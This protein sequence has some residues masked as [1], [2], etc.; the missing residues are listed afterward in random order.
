M[1]AISF[2][3]GIKSSHLRSSQLRDLIYRGRVLRHAKI[4]GDDGAAGS[5]HVGGDTQDEPMSDLTQTLTTQ[6]SQ[7]DRGDPKTASVMAVYEDDAG[8]EQ[9]WKRSITSQGASEYRINNRVVTA[10]QYNEA[11]EAENILIKARNFLVFQG[12]VEAI[13]SQSPKDLTRLIEQISGSLE[14]KAEYDRRKE[15]AEQ[16]TEHQNNNLN[17][18]RGINSEV[19]QYQ[20]QKREAEHY[21]AKVD[22]RNRAIVTHVLWKLFHFQRVMEESGE[23]IQRHQENLKE[24]Q[25]GLEK[26]EARLEEARKDQAKA[27]REASKLERTVKAKRREIEDQEHGLIPVDEKMAITERNVKSYTAKMAE[28]SKEAETQRAIVHKLTKDLDLVGK[29]QAKWEGHWQKAAAHEGRE[30]SEADLREYKSLKEQVNMRASAHQTKVDALAREQK[31]DEDTVNS[32]RSR[33]DSAQWQVQRFEEE[34]KELTGRRDRI[35][36]QLKQTG[37]EINAKKKDLNALS[38]ERLRSTQKQTELDEKLQD[39]L[40]ALLD[41]DDG[42]RQTEREV[43]M[44]ETIATLK[45]IYPGVRG[46]VGELCKPRQ[47]K[48]GDAVS[49]VLGRHFDS[50]VVDTEKTAKDCIQY[51]RDQRAGQATFI[52]L[53]T[54]Q[55]KTPNPKLKGMHSG[56][57]MA[58]DTIEY[59]NAY[60]RAM[61]YACGNAVVCD[62]LAI[63]KY[64][65]YDKGVE[66]KAVTLDGIIIHR[67]G[68]ITGGRGP[69]QQNSRR[70]DEAAVEDLRVMRD[71]FMA[72][73]AAL[74]KDGK[75]R[76][77]EESLLGELTGLEQSVSYRKEE[78]KALERNIESKA[79]E[80]SF[81]Q[82][83]LAELQRKHEEKDQALQALRREL[84]EHRQAVREV[85]DEVLGDFCRRLG[86]HDIREYEAQQGS[87][88]QEGAQKRL[89]FTMQRS[90]LESQLSF[91]SQ[92][93]QS[94]QDRLDRLRDKANHDEKLLRELQAEKDTID[95]TLDAMK[96]ELDQ[97]QQQLEQQN[98]QVTTKA[99]KVAEKRR[100]VQKRS[101]DVEGVRKSVAGLEADIQRNAAGR[102]VLLRRCK[103]E[104][105]RIPLADDSASLEAIPV[106]E[107]LRDD[108]DAMDID[109]D[110]NTTTL[111]D[112]DV[113]DYGVQPDFDELD[114]ELKQ[115]C[116]VRFLV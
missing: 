9:Y 106:D 65:C 94:T 8:D 84:E 21:A 79:K 68:L 58:I 46:R 73:L 104:D 101:K 44:K 61:S 56:M 29:A 25:R 27:A 24:F 35:A 75:R 10:Q 43:R 20:E 111:H 47:K 15:V 7:S 92:R 113:R 33:L 109:E 55:V 81:V 50:V 108:P 93:S 91:E 22:E 34:I 40:R 76:A 51:L 70:W 12:D 5:G 49:T 72:E 17:R 66:A 53:D 32:L 97:L 90:K 45:R 67:G 11:L 4:N 23:E 28:I 110:P 78:R 36:V 16:A 1:D 114:D 14:Y 63:A 52:P 98:D 96:A 100:D 13:A 99:E 107:A 95:S 54:I 102:Y 83:E 87:R 38:S 39:V 105:V 48:Y 71:K 85:E 112:P 103:L 26:Y 42:R 60:E 69:G 86:Y 57:R 41:A 62:D 77:A 37:D 31:T 64:I 88:Q 80:L 74:P 6:N 19:K 30:L 2:V 59:D 3:L 115:V 82:R 89:E 116:D 18:R